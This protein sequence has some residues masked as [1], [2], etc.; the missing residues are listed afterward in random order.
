MPFANS[1]LFQKFFSTKQDILTNVGYLAF[2]LP[3]ITD[4]IIYHLTVRKN[5]HFSAEQKKTMISQNWS[6]HSFNLVLEV[7]SLILS[8]HIIK[9]I[10]K[11][12][13]QADLAFYKTVGG[14]LAMI[15]AKSLIRPF[16]MIKFAEKEKGDKKKPGQGQA[17]AN[18]AHP[19]LDLNANPQRSASRSLYPV[20]NPSLLNTGSTYFPAA[21]PR[22]ATPIG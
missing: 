8:K 11:G 14:F 22:L 20:V 4:P 3:S 13:P 19:K 1:K 6:H 17:L 2:F 5:N 15:L 9:A 16:V 21:T 10:F 18:P 7:F 12:K